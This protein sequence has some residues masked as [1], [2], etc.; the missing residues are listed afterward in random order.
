MKAALGREAWT[1]PYTWP[2][3]LLFVLNVLLFLV[4]TFPRS[5]QERRTAEEALALRAE[6]EAR[7]AEMAAVRTRAQTVK[8]N[9][10]EAGRFYREVVPA[11]PGHSAV[12]LHDVNSEARALGI[13]LERVASASKEL[14]RL[15]LAEIAITAPVAGTYQ[16]VGGLLQRLERSPHF[17]VVDSVQLRERTADGG[18]AELS[19]KLNAYCH[20]AA[21]VQPRGRR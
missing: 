9:I 16:Q 11:C 2:F 6:L 3:L 19:L 17:L 5:L 8:A 21:A 13:K 12:V 10:A 7:R 18:G 20:D 4:F 1:R 14:D 15:P